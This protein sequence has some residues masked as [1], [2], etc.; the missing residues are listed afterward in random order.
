MKVPETIS[1]GTSLGK[2]TWETTRSNLVNTTTTGT[3]THVGDINEGYSVLSH[4]PFL[5]PRIS[6]TPSPS[7]PAIASDAGTHILNW[8]SSIIQD[9]KHHKNRLLYQTA[10]NLSGSER[11]ASV[12][13][14]MKSRM[15]CK[16]CE[17]PAR[18]SKPEYSW[19]MR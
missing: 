9:T 19:T 5:K 1:A 4:S 10:C 3:E 8:S 17:P 11:L 14:E 7:L 18:G 6:S 15:V 12:R 13:C 2:R 16:S